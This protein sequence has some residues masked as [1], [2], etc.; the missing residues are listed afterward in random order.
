[1][2]VRRICLYGEK[3]LR[4]KTKPVNFPA[5]KKKTAAALADLFETM[6]AAGGVGLAANQAGLKLRLAVIKI[7]AKDGPGAEL[8]LINPVLVSG[9]GTQDGEEGCLSFPG[10]FLQV[11]RFLKIKVRALDERGQP[12]E[13][14][15]EGFPA[16]AVQHEMDHLG[17]VLFIDR[18]PP[19]AKLKLKPLLPRM[20][21][22][23]A[24]MEKSENFA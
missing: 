15:A 22:E 24:K 18:L 6:A 19:S 5:D 10:L 2:A 9:E 4:Q 21:R 23:W 7:P 14:S 13:I 1:M 17:G 12:V 3:I 11:R 16:R 20:K 8:V